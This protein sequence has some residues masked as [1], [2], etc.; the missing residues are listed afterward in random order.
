MKRRNKLK[1]KTGYTTI[2]CK[3]EQGDLI[4]EYCRENGLLVSAFIAQAAV[5]KIKSQQNVN[6][7]VKELDREKQKE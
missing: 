3:G 6:D 1:Y 2:S 5:D 7:M 4:R